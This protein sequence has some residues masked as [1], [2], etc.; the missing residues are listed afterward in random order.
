MRKF[1]EQDCDVLPF[2]LLVPQCHHL[3]DTYFPVVIDYFQSQIVRARQPCLQPAS[4]TAPCP[5]TRRVTHT[6]YAPA[7][8]TYTHTLPVT[9]PGDTVAH[10]HMAQITAL[11]AQLY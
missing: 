11:P 10:S 8:R 2:K 9:S 1:L 4:L 7:P 6:H 3:L 5:A